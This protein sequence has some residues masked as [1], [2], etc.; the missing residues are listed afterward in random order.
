M[1]R[2]PARHSLLPTNFQ[3]VVILREMK[4]EQGDRDLE[5][6]RELIFLYS[7]NILKMLTDELERYGIL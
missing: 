3:E 7:V 1:Q 6:I 5:L 2:D 4:F